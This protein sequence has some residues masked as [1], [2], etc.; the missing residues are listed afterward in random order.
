MI[1]LNYG[2]N[3]FDWHAS[4]NA[5]KKRRKDSLWSTGKVVH[6][7]ETAAEVLRNLNGHLTGFACEKGAI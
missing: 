2:I 4:K 7:K 5:I 6:V 1:I 3:R